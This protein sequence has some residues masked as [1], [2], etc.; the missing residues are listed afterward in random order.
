[1]TTEE[2]KALAEV[3][4]LPPGNP[5]MGC[6]CLRDGHIRKRWRPNGDHILDA[7]SNCGCSGH[8]HKGQVPWLLERVHKEIAERDAEI[9]VLKDVLLKGADESLKREG[10]IRD[11]ERGI[12]IIERVELEAKCVAMQAVVEAVRKLLAAYMAEDW[13]Q[14]G[15]PLINGLVLALDALEE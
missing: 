10:T 3:L 14:E 15:D 9:E 5:C 13:G 11:T 12:A 8:L 6:G 1:V 7:C 2:E 4:D